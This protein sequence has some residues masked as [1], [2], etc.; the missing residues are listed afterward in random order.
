MQ[1]PPASQQEHTTNSISLPFARLFT[2]SEIV[3]REI[4]ISQLVLY[5]CT[6][7]TFFLR[8]LSSLEC[9]GFASGRAG[10]P[11]SISLTIAPRARSM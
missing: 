1:V 5:Y 3:L 6:S 8:L 2:W 4:E 9:N 11:G 10:L 7:V